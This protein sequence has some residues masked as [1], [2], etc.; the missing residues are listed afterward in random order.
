MSK[1]LGRN[2]TLL[3][4]GEVLDCQSILSCSYLNQ[5]CDGGY[6]YLVGKW[7]S[8]YGLTTSSCMRYKGSHDGGCPNAIL[9]TGNID[10][11]D[12]DNCARRNRI[13]S[14]EYGYVGG[15]YECAN[16]K[17]IMEEVY[18]NGPVVAALD[19]PSHLF[20]YAEGIFNER[21]T[22]HAKVCDTN[23]LNG[24]E[25]TNHAV[26]IVGWGEKEG[27]NDTPTKYWVVRN[28]WGPSWGYGGYFLLLRGINLGGIENQAVYMVPD[29]QRGRTKVTLET[30]QRKKARRKYKPQDPLTP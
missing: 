11:D 2:Y 16:E 21:P 3:P 29:T 22:P 28:S 18:K 7:A 30:I 14:Q 8:M 9:P 1:S 15:C 24:W 26:A 23:V 17:L 20:S 12:D 25:Y 19:A 4:A 6:P 5:G 27:D 13:Y 10:N